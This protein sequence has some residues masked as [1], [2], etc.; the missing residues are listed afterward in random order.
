MA[1]LFSP[2]RLTVNIHYGTRGR[3][4]GWEGSTSKTKEPPQS[5]YYTDVSQGQEAMAHK[6]M[7]EEGSD[8]KQGTI[9]AMKLR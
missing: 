6:R 1:G 7:E 9:V 5:Q 8:R 3:Q 4:S 2:N